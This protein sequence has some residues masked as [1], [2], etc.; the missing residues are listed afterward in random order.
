MLD[1]LCWAKF[2]ERPDS[3]N[4]FVSIAPLSFVDQLRSSRSDEVVELD[5][6]KF[7][8]KSHIPCEDEYLE[9]RYRKDLSVTGARFCVSKP[10]KIIS[11]SNV[12]AISYRGS[13]N[14]SIILIFRCGS[15]FLAST[16]A[17]NKAAEESIKG[18]DVKSETEITINSPAELLETK[19]QKSFVSSSQ[20]T[21]TIIRTLEEGKQKTK[22]KGQKDV[23]I[24]ELLVDEHLP[25]FK[26]SNFKTSGQNG[27]LARRTAAAAA[28]KIATKLDRELHFHSSLLR[29]QSPS[30][31]KSS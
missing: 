25:N 1:S 4:I 14:S 12:L 24:P 18:T 7:S 6:A 11:E 21:E 9:V 23:I 29:I 16:D 19:I 8:F 30:C 13:E 20:S 26:M 15:S 2:L 28:R 17:H 3:S 27:L 22:K 5:V 31:F 10:E